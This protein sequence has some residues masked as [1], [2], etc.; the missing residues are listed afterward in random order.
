MVTLRSIADIRGGIQKQPKRAPKS[1]AFPYLR[2]ANVLR[3]RVDL[4]QMHEME[5]F[6]S[7]LETYRLEPQDLLIVEGNGSISEIGRSALWTGAVPNCVHQ[8]HIIRVRVKEADPGYVNYYW[9]SPLGSDAAS[10]GAVTSAGLHSL[11]VRKIA[12]M[13]VPLPPPEEQRE[14]VRRVNALFALADRIERRVAT[15]AARAGRLTQAVLARA[16][17]GELVPTEAELARAEG[18]AYEPA[19]ELLGRIREE[20]GGEVTPRKRKR[21]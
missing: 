1:N 18:R 16:F 4:S 10:G 17:R 15:A 3:G 2:V 12:E 20:S 19:G 7:E 6:G 21:S 13:T 14:I 11:S 5:L 8:N 9:N